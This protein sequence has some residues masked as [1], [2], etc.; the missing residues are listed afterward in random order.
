[1]TFFIES[2]IACALFTLI[3]FLFGHQKNRNVYNHGVH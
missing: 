2:L 1:M 3:V